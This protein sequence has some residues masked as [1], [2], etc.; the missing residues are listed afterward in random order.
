MSIVRE[1]PPFAGFDQLRLSLAVACSSA[2][3]P[4]RRLWF[5]LAGSPAAPWQAA[6]GGK[7]GTG[8]R[9][10]CALPGAG[11]ADSGAAPAQTTYERARCAVAAQRAGLRRAS[12]TSPRSPRRGCGQRRTRQ[13]GRFDVR[14]RSRG[15][16][17]AGRTLAPRKTC[18]RSSS[19]ADGA[20]ARSRCGGTAR[21]SSAERVQF[22]HAASN[23]AAASCPCARARTTSSTHES[24]EPASAP[25]NSASDGHQL[26]DLAM[27][28]PDRVRGGRVVGTADA[29][30]VLI[31]TRP[32][33]ISSAARLGRPSSRRPRPCLP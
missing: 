29:R 14:R 28:G 23:S 13:H 18:F 25:R 11:G 10:A 17:S 24:I 26:Q 19:R 3:N 16:P 7:L 9:V 5:W 22:P 31:A 8:T 30:P 1:F 2:G 21:G 27:R 15:S 6:H 4:A 33:R 20:I 12:G 32:V